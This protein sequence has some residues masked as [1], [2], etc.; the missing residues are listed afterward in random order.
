MSRSLVAAALIALVCVSAP[1][2]AQDTTVNLGGWWGALRPYLQDVIALVVAGVIGALAKLAYTLTGI[3]IEKRHRD[4]LHSAVMTGV[5]GAMNFIGAKANDMT[6]DVRN[7][8]IADAIRWAEKSVPD[9]IKAL[10]VT[11]DA[12]TQLASSKIAILAEAPA[13]VPVTTAPAAPNA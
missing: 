13:S 9:A 6:I 10:G 1:A 12:L 5:S 11:P 3:N 8:V 2:F 4:A 7:R